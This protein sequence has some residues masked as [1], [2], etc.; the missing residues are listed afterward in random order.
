MALMMSKLYEALLEAGA[1]EGKAREAAEEAAAYETRF[2]RVEND[3]SVL[4]WMV[5]TNIILTLGILWRV[6]TLK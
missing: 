2:Q 6:M 4:K 3:L 1:S 5:G